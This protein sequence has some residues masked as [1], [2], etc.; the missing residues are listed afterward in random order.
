MPYFEEAFETLHRR[1]AALQEATGGQDMPALQDLQLMLD[2]QFAKAAELSDGLDNRLEEFTEERQGIEREMEEKV[3]WVANM[4][5]K[6][7][8]V[9]DMSGSDQDLLTRLDNAK[10]RLYETTHEDHTRTGNV[11]IDNEQLK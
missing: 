8:A 7:A 1:M 10:V 2:D 11:I 5:D 9:D 4:R 6:L 3:K